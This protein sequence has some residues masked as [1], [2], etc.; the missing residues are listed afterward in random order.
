MRNPSFAKRVKILETIGRIRSCVEMID[1]DCEDLIRKMFQYFLAIV[2]MSRIENIRAFMQTIM[3]LILN[4]S[5][6]ISLPLLFIL[7]VVLRKE[8]NFSSAIHEMVVNVV[9]QC[10]QKLRPHFSI[11][12]ITKK[13]TQEAPGTKEESLKISRIEKCIEK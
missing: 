11:Q 13:E 3:S 12:K 7:L 1:L 9:K 6:A 2:S 10:V 5:D 4:D 8:Q